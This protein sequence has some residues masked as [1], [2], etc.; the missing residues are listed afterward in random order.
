MIAD[1][2]ASSTGRRSPAALMLLVLQTISSKVLGIVYVVMFGVG[3]ALGM[4]L[5]TAIISAQLHRSQLRSS[6][7]ARKLRSIA[8]IVTLGIG[9]FL[10]F[11]A[12]ASAGLFMM[13]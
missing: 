6:E 2:A 1:V 12:G 3:S 10:M 11:K 13:I 9:F 5:L 8:A 4:T 7:W